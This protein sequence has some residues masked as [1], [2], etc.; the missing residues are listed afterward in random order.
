M[1]AILLVLVWTSLGTGAAKAQT[2]KATASAAAH[3]CGERRRIAVGGGAGESV[4]VATISEKM[5]K[6]ADLHYHLSGGAYAESFIRAAVEDGLCVDV[7]Q[8]AFTKCPAGGD[9]D[10]TIVPASDAYKSQALYDQLINAFSMRSF[11]PYAGVSGHDHFFDTLE[12]SEEQTRRTSRNGWMKSPRA[13][14]AK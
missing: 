10:K 11:V 9:G 2:Q 12:N 5:P 4:A 14:G 7:K 1:G 3:K 6:G 8:L 13:R